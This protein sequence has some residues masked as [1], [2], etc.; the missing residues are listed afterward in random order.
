MLPP[1]EQRE[2]L[3]DLIV[4]RHSQLDWLREIFSRRAERSERNGSIL[5]VAVIFLAALSV[6]Q[7][8][9]VKVF[10]QSSTAV[11][12]FYALIGVSIAAISGVEA[13]FK[14]E[15]KA[16]ELRNLA[17]KCQNARLIHNSEWAQKFA[18]VESVAAIDAAREL[19]ALQDKALAEIQSEGA[20]LGVNV[21][22][23]LIPSRREA[24]EDVADRFERD[25]MPVRR[26]RNPVPDDLPP[27]RR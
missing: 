21:G 15:A 9:A 3:N 20:R 25:E 6:S 23:E 27:P 4:T 26:R 11:A 17:V 13:A 14:F 2:F 5:R 7:S 10:D 19:L 16:N 1:D 8:V 24:L 22:K 12:V 18:I